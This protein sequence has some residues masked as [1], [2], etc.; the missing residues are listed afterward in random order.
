MKTVRMEKKTLLSLVH[1]AWK[2]VN[3][4]D[5]GGLIDPF[6]LVNLQAK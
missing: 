6:I 5:I 3:I 1:I 2:I 4:H